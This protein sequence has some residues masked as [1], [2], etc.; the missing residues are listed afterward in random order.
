MRKK[1]MKNHKRGSTITIPKITLSRFKD[2]P[3]V[4]I[5]KTKIPSDGTLSKCIVDIYSRKVVQQ[6][7]ETEK[8]LALLPKEKSK[9]I[10]V[11]RRMQLQID[12]REGRIRDAIAMLKGK[13][14]AV[15]PN[16]D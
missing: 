4:N 13:L 6:A 10:S 11:K 9:P 7:R 12:E 14:I 2:V 5:L 3:T 1:P 15:D 8:I 16:D